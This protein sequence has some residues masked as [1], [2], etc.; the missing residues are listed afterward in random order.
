M[1]GEQ[2]QDEPSIIAAETQ[3]FVRILLPATHKDPQ[4]L[5]LPFT[6]R[7]HAGVSMPMPSLH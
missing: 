1:A 6:S 5:E 2:T 7:L 3:Q 4:I